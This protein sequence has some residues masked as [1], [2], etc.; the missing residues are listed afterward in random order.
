MRTPLNNVRPSC[1]CASAYL[2][3]YV[4]GHLWQRNHL[5]QWQKYFPR[6]NFVHTRS[7]C[8]S[9]LVQTL[10]LHRYEKCSQ[11]EVSEY[12]VSTIPNGWELCEVQAVWKVEKHSLHGNT[13][14]MEGRRTQTLSLKLAC[15]SVLYILPSTFLVILFIIILIIFI[16]IV[17]IQ[18]PVCF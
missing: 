17:I 12:S 5:A 18:L 16:L 10:R 8:C 9:V 15:L 3:S 1:A 13:D 6:Y 11:R 2:Q 14:C 4:A 7:H